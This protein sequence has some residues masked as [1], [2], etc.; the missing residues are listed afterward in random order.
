MENKMYIIVIILSMLLFLQCSTNNINAQENG[1]GDIPILI[2]SEYDNIYVYNLK[3]KERKQIL[4]N[5]INIISANIIKVEYL[6]K[7]I[8]EIIGSTN[9][10]NG[11]IYLYDM[12]LSLLLKEYYY[13]THMESWEYFEFH[14]NELFKNREYIQGE[15]IS[16][17]FRNNS[18]NI[19]YNFNNKGIIHI[20]GIRDY[21][22][23]LNDKEEVIYSEDIDLYYEYSNKDN[24]YYLLEKKID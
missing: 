23:E 17:I 20:Y 22:S 18:L 10:G 24:K 7:Y 1:T 12:D 16:E 5:E 8:I 6:N 3:T 11:N 19:E 9:R 21:I 13:N 4:I 14:E 2:E 15:T